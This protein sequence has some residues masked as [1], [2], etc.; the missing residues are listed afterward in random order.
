IVVGK[1]MIEL[2]SGKSLDPALDLSFQSGEE[3]KST[4]I[5]TFRADTKA[6]KEMLK[7]YQSTENIP[8]PVLIFSNNKKVKVT[9]DNFLIGSGHPSNLR[10]KARFVKDV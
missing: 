4:D 8:F 7:K 2:K 10:I 3:G 6:R 9:E 5:Q 1:Y